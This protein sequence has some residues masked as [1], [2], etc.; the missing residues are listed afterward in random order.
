MYVVFTRL[1]V[2]LPVVYAAITIMR[3]DGVGKVDAI[4][5]FEVVHVPHKCPDFNALNLHQSHEAGESLLQIAIRTGIDRSTILKR[6][7]GLGLQQRSR[8][9]AGLVRAAAMTKEARA[10]QSAAAH[11]AVRGVRHSFEVLQKH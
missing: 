7:K 6:W 2:A 9:A 5:R 1:A 10:A 8:S 4:L 11:D 3:Y